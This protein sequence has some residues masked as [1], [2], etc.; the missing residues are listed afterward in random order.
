MRV[1]IDYRPALRDRSGVGEYTHELVKALLAAYPPDGAAPDLAL[2]LFS[3]SWKDRL[4]PATE[5]AGAAAID[6]RIPGRALNFAWHRL[7]WPAVERLTGR[8]FDVA[9]S[10][11]PLLL[12]S[13]TAA[14]VVTI[15][16]LYF[17]THPERT[18][19][20]V[21]RDYPALVRA[22]AHRA[23]A[24]L[25]PS[26][27]PAAEIEREL[28]VPR[29]RIA[30]CPPGAPDWT[31][32]RAAPGDGYVLFFSTARGAQERR[33]PAGR[34]RAADRHRYSGALRIRHRH[35]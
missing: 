14:Q 4:A 34:V 11:H 19:R 8:A 5:L 2:S 28:G 31:P 26:A 20:E 13:R 24:I 10:S 35:R 30:I 27:Y 17:L 16:D 7:G 29:E 22:H 9:H 1:L 21:R 3:S 15:H 18:R 32:R 25:T 33:R 6:R 23:D 12:P